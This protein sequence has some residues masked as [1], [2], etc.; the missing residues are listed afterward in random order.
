MSLLCDFL[1]WATIVCVVLAFIFV[2]LAVVLL[3]VMVLWLE[4]RAVFCCGGPRNSDG[5][6]TTLM[7]LLALLG[8]TMREV[9]GGWSGD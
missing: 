7:S 3:V 2:V 5:E 8:L 4:V 9:S 1:L 6:E